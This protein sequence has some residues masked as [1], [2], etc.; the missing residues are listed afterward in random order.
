MLVAWCKNCGIV[1]WAV[2]VLSAEFQRNIVN[3]PVEQ[4]VDCYHE[5]KTDMWWENVTG[6]SQT[7]NSGWCREYLVKVHITLSQ[8][9]NKKVQLKRNEEK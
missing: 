8:K 6:L 1:S 7:L 4:C 2:R 3:L 9:E 5:L